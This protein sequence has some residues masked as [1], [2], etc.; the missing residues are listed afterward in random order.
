MSSKLF[1]DSGSILAAS[2]VIP[3]ESVVSAKATDKLDLNSLGIRLGGTG[4]P[5]I[6]VLGHFRKKG[7][8]IF[9]NWT[10]GQRVLTVEL[11]N[12]K[13]DRLELGCSDPDELVKALVR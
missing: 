1:W 4:L 9:C 3:L 12:S 2:L 7:T 6:A 11:K 8:R 13:F 5:G 10:K